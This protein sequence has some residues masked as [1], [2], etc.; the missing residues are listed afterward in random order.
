VGVVLCLALLVFARRRPR[1]PEGAGGPEG[2]DE[3]GPAGRDADG[4]RLVWP[5]FGEDGPAFSV[6]AAVAAAVGLGLF[7]A[8][9]SPP[10]P[11]VAPVVAGVAYAAFR[12][13]RGRTLQAAVAAGALAVT[14]LYYVAAQ[15][16]YRH[17]PDFIWPQQFEAVHVLGLLVIFLLAGDALR[18]AL[19][20][21]RAG[22]PPTISGVDGGTSGAP[23][24]GSPSGPPAHEDTT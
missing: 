12:W 5:P 8:L 16:R 19:I 15:I 11:L 7:A 22:A 14:G 23:G 3:T 13:T 17:P 18:E 9:N 20:A 6:R 21:R 1:G 2:P 4:P 24:G 10:L